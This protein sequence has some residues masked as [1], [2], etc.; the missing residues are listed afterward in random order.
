MLLLTLLVQWYLPATVRAV[1]VHRRALSQTDVASCCGSRSSLLLTTGLHFKTAAGPGL[2]VRGAD[3]WG[4]RLG[5]LRGTA[6]LQACDSCEHSKAFNT[7]LVFLRFEA[8]MIIDCLYEA[9]QM[10]G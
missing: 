2:G 5:A 8:K 1:A 3:Q 6:Q 4:H 7:V 9:S 10:L